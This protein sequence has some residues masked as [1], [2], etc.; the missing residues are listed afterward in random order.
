[1]SAIGPN[2]HVLGSA[3]ETLKLPREA[4]AFNFPLARANVQIPG[5]QVLEEIG[6]GGMGVVYKARQS[7]LNRLVALKMLLP[8]SHAGEADLARLRAEAEAIAALRHPNIIQIYEI[9]EQHG[10]PFLAL[11]YC[12][13]GSLDRK[14]NGTPLPA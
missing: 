5:Y 4:G 14:I 8:G 10:R 1:M 7:S 12:A 9:G 3:A 2:S 13:G 6:R 11:E